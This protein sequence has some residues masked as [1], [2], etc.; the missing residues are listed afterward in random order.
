MSPKCAAPTTV[1]AGG[2]AQAPTIGLDV[3]SARLPATGVGVYVTELAAALDSLVGR[4]VLRLGMRPTGP[5]RPRDPSA[6]ETHMRGRLY[7]G[8]ILGF[9]DR[10]ARSAGCRL[11]HYTNA[12]APLRATVPFVLTIHDLSVVRYPNSHPISRL[13]VVPFMLSAAHRARLIIVPSTATADE[14]RRL[15]HVSFER[16]AV[17]SLAAH[18]GAVAS[19]DESVLARLALQP[20]RYV[21]ALG[22]IE[23]R[24]NHVRLLA[25]FERVAEAL[26]DLRL[27][28]V[29][30]PGWRDGRF[31]RALERCRVRDRVVLAG[32]QPEPALAA[33]LASCS[34]MA[35]PSLYEGFGLPVLEAMAAGAPVVTSRISSMPEVAGGAA[36]LV[37][38]MDVASIATGIMEALRRR[39][40][41]V[42]AGHAR[43]AARTW[44]D[45]GRDTLGAYDRALRAGG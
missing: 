13:A 26:P 8:W 16:I 45:V 25:A 29:G 20:G 33:L 43:A 38:P 3:G 21:L 11:V 18:A 22:T 12:V 9:A 5:L 15:L 39:D 31:R 30:G 40:E 4:R 19:Q 1:N 27:V 32:H 42:A 28:L 10:E 7:L 35:Y 14:V 37:D 6:G 44:L 2:D 34:V 23:P 24:K 36:V 17:I 41:L